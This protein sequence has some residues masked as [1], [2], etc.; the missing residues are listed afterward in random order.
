MMIYV[1]SVP[2]APSSKIR[3]M[4]DNVVIPTTRLLRSAIY[5]RKS[6]L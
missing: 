5:G 3:K 4:N 2:S 1:T 6:K